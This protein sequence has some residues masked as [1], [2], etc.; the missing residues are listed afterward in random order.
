M[1]SRNVRYLLAAVSAVGNALSLALPWA[2]YGDINVA[3]R[4]IPGCNAR[5]ATVEPML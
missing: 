1:S 5:R 2:V 4:N 3:L